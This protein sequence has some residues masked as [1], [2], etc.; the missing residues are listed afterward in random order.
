MTATHLESTRLVRLKDLLGSLKRLLLS[1]KEREER[2]SRDLERLGRELEG[3]KLWHGTLFVSLCRTPFHESA[4]LT[5]AL[6]KVTIVPFRL[7][8]SKFSSH[9]SLPTPS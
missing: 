2:R 3:R 1:G 6:P 9:V 5:E 8:I 7:M 4:Q